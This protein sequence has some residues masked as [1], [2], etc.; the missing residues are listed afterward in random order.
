[1]C[2]RTAIFGNLLWQARVLETFFYPVDIPDLDFH[3]K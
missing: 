3:D 2:R 1:M